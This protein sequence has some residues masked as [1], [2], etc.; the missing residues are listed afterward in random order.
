M[1]GGGLGAPQEAGPMSP[2]GGGTRPEAGAPAVWGG[3]GRQAAWR[4]GRR[5]AVVCREQGPGEA[6]GGR[7]GLPEVVGREVVPGEGFSLPTRP[8]AEGAVRVRRRKG[9]VEVPAGHGEAVAGRG[10]VAVCLRLAV[11][12]GKAETR[13]VAGVL[14]STFTWIDGC[15]GVLEEARMAIAFCS[16]RI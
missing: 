16:A 7:R 4:V 11:R 14:E 2:P 13:K 6:V 1:A 10:Q 12:A 8:G 3:R 9:W 15:R 5:R